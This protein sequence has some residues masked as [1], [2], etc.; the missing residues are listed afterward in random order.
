MEISLEALVQTQRQLI[1]LIKTSTALLQT[2]HT[3][4]KIESFL[5]SAE[6]RYDY[7]HSLPIVSS[8]LTFPTPHT[9][10]SRQVGSC[11]QLTIF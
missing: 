8:H 9:F 11:I 2:Y 1:N 4:P 7:A 5:Y 10:L 6:V 3:L